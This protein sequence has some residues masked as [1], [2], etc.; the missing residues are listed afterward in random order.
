MED[1][2]GTIRLQSNLRLNRNTWTRKD[3]LCKKNSRMFDE[4]MRRACS[5]YTQGDGIITWNKKKT[6]SYHSSLYPITE[7]SA[8]DYRNTNSDIR[9]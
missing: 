5:I 1:G 9:L 8:E 7:E 2:Q 6:G 4:K 3:T